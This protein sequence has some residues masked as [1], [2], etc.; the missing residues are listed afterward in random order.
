MFVINLSLVRYLSSR[1]L[2]CICLLSLLLLS[3]RGNLSPPPN[4]KDA[5]LRVVTDIRRMV[6][7]QRSDLEVNTKHIVSSEPSANASEWSSEI[8]KHYLPRKSF[9]TEHKQTL[10]H[11][12]CISPGRWN[13]Q[14]QELFQFV[15]STNEPCQHVYESSEE[16]VPEGRKT[17]L[18]FRCHVEKT[19]TQKEGLSHT[20][21]SRVLF[22]LVPTLHR[23]LPPL[24]HVALLFL[25]I[26]DVAEAAT[27]AFHYFPAVLQAINKQIR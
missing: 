16:I 26:L 1:W 18:T 4:Y 22:Y 2:S 15:W 11:V 12:T 24:Q 10:T 3:F 20:D 8:S 17:L 9:Q 14:L 7:A 23:P 13:H 21:H 27:Q 6:K 25:G 19:I 5:T